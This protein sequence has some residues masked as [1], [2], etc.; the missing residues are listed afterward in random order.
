MSSVRRAEDHAVSQLD[1]FDQPK[2]GKVRRDHPS[3]AKMAAMAVIPRSGT[4]RWKVLQAVAL[5]PRTDEQIQDDLHMSANTERPRRVELVEM[6]W[7]EEWKGHVGRTRAG[8]DAI[9]WR[10]TEEGA[11][12]WS[13]VVDAEP[14]EV[15]G[16]RL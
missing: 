5:V 11:R 12:R 7:I 15:A 3:T 8:L 16:G 1:L 6:G 4:A 9:V 2:A 14:V 10:L 13:R